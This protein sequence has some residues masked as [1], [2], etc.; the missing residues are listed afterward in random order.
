MVVICHG[1]Q[2]TVLYVDLKSSNPVGYA[3]QFKSTRQFVRYALGLLEEFHGSPLRL[4]REQYVVLYGGAKPLPIPKLPTVP[5][6]G[7]AGKTQPDK[8]F[9]REVPNDARIYLRELLG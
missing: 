8:A 1:T 4:E 3:G 6:L 7:T 9:K 5:K 2:L